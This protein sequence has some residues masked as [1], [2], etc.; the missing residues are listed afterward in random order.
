MGVWPPGAGL[1]GL[2][3]NHLMLLRSN[4]VVVSDEEKADSIRQV[5]DEKVSASEPSMTRR[6]HLQTLSKQESVRNSWSSVGGPAYGPHGS[7]RIDGTSSSQALMRNMR[8]CH[9]M[10]RERHK[11]LQPRG[12]IPMAMAGAEQPVVARK[13]L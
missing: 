3:P 7:R 10:P 8:T 5:S 2:I 4:D 6:N 12:S 13:G 9:G 1:Q 11:W